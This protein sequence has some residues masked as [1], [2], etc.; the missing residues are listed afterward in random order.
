MS[1]TKWSSNLLFLLVAIGTEA[2]IANVWKFSYLAGE[3]GGGLFVFIYFAALIV[4]AVP[5]L[6]AE[7]LLGRIGGKSVVGNM[8]ELIEHYGLAR[9]WKSFGVLALVCVSLILSFYFVVCGWMLYYFLF[10]VGHGFAG[11]TVESAQQVEAGMM[12]SP[13]A[14][15]ACSGIFVA[16][17]AYVIGFGVN[18]GVERVASILTPLRF[19]I[20]IGMFVYAVIFADARSAAKFLFTVRW[21]DLSWHIVLVGVGQAFFS[22][23]IGVGVMMTMGAYM[24]REFS[25][26]R[27]AI[28]VAFAQGAVALLAGMSIFPLVFQYGLEPA[29]G[30]GLIFVT[31]PVAFGKMPG[32]SV[33]GA[34][35][36]LLLSFAALT[37]TIVIMQS[38]VAWLEERYP[39]SRR[40]LAWIT[41]GVLWAAGS[42]TVLSFGAWKNVYPLHWLGIESKRTFFDLLDY[43]TS[44]LLMPVGGVMVCVMAGWSLSRAL[45]AQEL[46]LPGHAFDMWRS[47]VRYI[48]PAGVVILFIS[49]HW[50]G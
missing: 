21:A 12:A 34:L 29:Q 25:I 33:F 28:T 22:L 37:A 36:F 31:L 13:W 11:V 3:N 42:F 23:G 24:K 2:G 32:G 6:I 45:V 43:L 26:P 19:V 46:G 35:L 49:S 20:M 4:M 50:L 18:R 5:A 8:H 16:L 14:M 17:S 7:M 30:P 27:A 1:Q 40:W 39:L 9:G 15:L 41:G 48:V 44:D 47:A 38:I 10:A